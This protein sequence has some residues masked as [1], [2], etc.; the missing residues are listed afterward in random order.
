M[1]PESFGRCSSRHTATGAFT[2]ER[3]EQNRKSGGATSIKN[4]PFVRVSSPIAEAL[5]LPLSMTGL[6]VDRVLWDCCTES[7]PY[8]ENLRRIDRI[9]GADFS[10]IHQPATA[11]WP[12]AEDTRAYHFN[13]FLSRPSMTAQCLLE[14]ASEQNDYR[15]VYYGDRRVTV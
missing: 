15:V 5:N 11:P 3:D 12:P 1:K 14:P 9:Q 13:S 4:I 10:T 6:Q 8:V 7:L 2:G